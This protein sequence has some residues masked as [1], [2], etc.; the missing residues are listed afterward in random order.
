MA[1]SLALVVLVW[2]KGS[3]TFGSK[4]FCY[5]LLSMMLWS[6]VTFGMR[7]SPDVHQAV[8][9]DRLVPT[10]GFALLVLY[11]HF[12]LAYTGNKGQR[13]ILFAS[14]LALVIFIA[15]TPT[16]LVVVRMVLAD[17]GYTPVLGPAGY[18]L[19]VG[20]LLMGAAIYNILRRY[21][22][23]SSY[24][25]RNRLLYLA[26]A[27]LFPIAGGLIDGF[28]NLP[29]AAIWANLI[30]CIICSVVIL[31][32]HLLDIRVVIRKSLVY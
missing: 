6:L 12:S 17:Y 23:S 11:Y 20:T 29:P 24:E 14:Y 4:I 10:F 16:P 19:A 2:R 7:S 1:I 3:W 18:S 25:E 32:Y 21:R 28:S 8:L 9:W 5:V 27:A 22:V 26:I 15:L 30:F 13:G 31:K